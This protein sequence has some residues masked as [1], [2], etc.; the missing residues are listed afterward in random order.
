MD[1]QDII[2]SEKDR[3]F[4]V[5]HECFLIYTGESVEDRK[6]FIRIGNWLEM[7]VELIPL[8]ENIIITDE[9]TGNPSFEQFNINLKYLKSNRYIGSGNSVHRFLDFQKVFNLDLTNASIVEVEKDIPE[10]STEKN[11]SE[12][13]QFIGVF[14]S[15]GNFKIV[16]GGKTIFDLFDLKNRY[17]SINDI[18]NKISLKTQN[19]RPSK[20]QGFY[21]AGSNPVF[22]SDENLVSYLF[23]LNYYN[24]FEKNDINPDS[25]SHI[26]YPSLNMINLNKI[27]KWKNYKKSSLTVFSDHSDRLEP[28]RKL[29]DRAAIDIKNFNGMKLSLNG[30]N[31]KAYPDSYNIKTVYEKKPE[32]I[33]VAFIKSIKGI[34][35]V[36]KKDKND[37]LLI[38]YSVFEEILPLLKSITT[39]VV[40]IDDGNKN[41]SKLA[42][43]GH[44]YIRDGKYN[45]HKAADFKNLLK[46][47]GLSPEE[48]EDLT[49]SPL[50]FLDEILHSKTESYEKYVILNNAA[51]IL[52]YFRNNTSERKKYAELSKAIEKYRHTINSPSLSNDNSCAS[53]ELVLLNE[54]IYIFISK[55]HHESSDFFDTIDEKSVEVCKD[56]KL[57]SYYTRILND[58]K[59]LNELL[60]LLK[61]STVSVSS[62]SDDLSDLKQRVEER[63]ESLI[64]NSDD[65][66]FRNSK[67]I[68]GAPDAKTP[69][70]GL[71]KKTEKLIKKPS[72]S[73]R[74]FTKYAGLIILLTFLA[75][76]VYYVA[77]FFERD[78]SETITPDREAEIALIKYD[79]HVADSE[80]FEYANTVAVINGYSPIPNATFREKNPHWIYPGNIFELHD[81]ET[82]VV[83]PGDTLWDIS[84]QKI[85]RTT[86]RIHDLIIE[87][88]KTDDDETAEKLVARAKKLA[89]TDS[90]K[91]LIPDDDT[92]RKTRNGEE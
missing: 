84:K 86:G 48:V 77:F 66:D 8:T 33:S 38:P 65:L 34:D 22:F 83:K 56:Q 54:N 27:S 78:P 14:Y 74:I 19:A 11:I 91:N 6:P 88:E 2:R 16:Y 79:I 35:P 12:K 46:L 7:P 40:V 85:I 87:A 50:L 60:F 1:I 23:P 21:I 75:G 25:V 64:V 30:L 69:A 15:N 92:F 39:P 9:V 67:D 10:L 42:A 43:T 81:G 57:Y 41:I 59:R 82:I 62:D 17:F 4:L 28:M 68:L 29:Y 5:D 32:D 49:R 31:I 13:N 73:K 72:S 90:Q 76:A 52:S 26:I 3:I 55:T 63:K 24:F 53:S 51:Y 89:I 36:I 45:L 20:G 70:A 47:S 71:L 61:N 37:L 44:P 18:N 80:I 58:R